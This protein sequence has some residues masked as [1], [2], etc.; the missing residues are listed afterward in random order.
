R[1]LFLI[2]LGALGSHLR[3]R[4]G[5]RQLTLQRVVRIVLR[6]QLSG[7]ERALQVALLERR[8]RLGGLSRRA[9][10]ALLLHGI[11][12]TGE[13]EQRDDAEVLRV[14]GAKPVTESERE[15][16]RVSDLPGETML[17]SAH[18]LQTEQVT[19]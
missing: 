11:L 6:G 19:S 8:L 14:H 10:S 2:E 9:L 4:N 18:W 17:S 15:A 1:V 16:A 7:E 12:A 13:R 3:E 5:D